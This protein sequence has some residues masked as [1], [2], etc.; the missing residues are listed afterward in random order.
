M[1]KNITGII[2]AGG[3]SSRMGTDKGLLLWK[4]KTFIAHIA[5]QLEPFV[6]EIILVSNHNIHDA[7][8]IKRVE[9]TVQGFGP[10]A[11]IHAGLGA[12]ETDLNFV[13]SCDTPKIDASVLKELLRHQKK[14]TPY[15]LIHFEYEEKPTLLTALYHKNSL[16][17]FEKAL[18]NQTQKL[19][20]VIHNLNTKVLQAHEE[21]GPK[22]VNINTPED[23]KSKL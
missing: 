6:D 2:L 9:D 11:G 1:K 14:Q 16:S 17:A 4:N 12:S 22:L 19:L 8:Q 15:D 13:I 21:L 23:Y 5:E 18:S 3:Q 20:W 10:V 7:L